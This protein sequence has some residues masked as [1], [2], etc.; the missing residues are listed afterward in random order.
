LWERNWS[1]QIAKQVVWLSGIVT[2]SQV[3]EIMRE[4]G[5]VDISSSS[6]W[7]LVERWGQEFQEIET[8]Q[9]VRAY[10][11]EEPIPIDPNRSLSAWE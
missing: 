9:Q 10:E 8:L 7:R 3:A 6:V 11:L 1:E 4:V 2:Y 5:Q